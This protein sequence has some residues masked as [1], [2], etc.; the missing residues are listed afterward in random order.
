LPGLRHDLV[1]RA[2]FF[3]WSPFDLVV[4]FGSLGL[5]L[6]CWGNSNASSA[7]S[8]Y[9]LGYR[10]IPGWAVILALTYG[11]WRTY[12]L[13]KGGIMRPMKFFRPFTLQSREILVRGSDESLAVHRFTIGLPDGRSLM[14]FGV[15]LSLGDFVMVRQPGHFKS[16]AYS[17]TSNESLRGSFDIVVKIYPGGHVSGFLDKLQVGETVMVSG[18][19]PVPWMA[20]AFTPGWQVGLVAFGVGITEALPVMCA[21]LRDERELRVVLLWAN[22]RHNDT[23]WH[24]ELEML[25]RAH[26]Q[27]LELRYAF[28]REQRQGCEHGRVDRGV[29]ERTFGSLDRSG[30]RFLVVG[31]RDMKLRTFAHL[32]A[33]GFQLP[34]LL[35]KRL[36]PPWHWRW[37]S[38]DAHEYEG[39][40]CSA[41]DGRYA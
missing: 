33:M 13:C 18:P 2:M 31:T 27:R 4:C 41:P 3:T 8:I 24:E 40:E 38:L 26:P 23:F 10:W 1:D 7:A 30:A 19:G 35:R 34:P 11:S 12:F 37:A 16:R 39:V 25:A 22:R 6:L 9:D 29:L 36:T 28:S 21:R 17:P 15:D 14:E 5:T 32:E 20:H